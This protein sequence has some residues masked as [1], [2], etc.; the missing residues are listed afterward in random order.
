MAKKKK[1]CNC[2]KEKSENYGPLVIVAPQWVLSNEAF[3]TFV[4]ETRHEGGYVDVLITGVPTCI[5]TP[6]HPCPKQ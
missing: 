2:K 5:P 4:Q 1:P 6:G 3:T